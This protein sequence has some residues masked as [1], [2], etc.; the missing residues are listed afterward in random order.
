Q[1]V[2]QNGELVTL[3]HQTHGDTG[4]RRLHRYTGVHQRQGSTADRGH[5]GRTVGLGDFRDHADGVRELVFLRQ[6]GSNTTAGQAA[7]ADFAATG[8]A[9]AATLTD[10][11]RREVVVQHE[12]VLL[13]A[14]QGIEQLCIARGT[15]GGND[16]RLGFT[17]G[18]QGRAMGPVQYANFDLQRTYSA[19]VTTVDTRLAINDVLANGAVFDLT[20]SGLD[21]IGGEFAFAFTGQGCDD[22]V[23]QLV[24]TAVAVLL[25]G[26]G[27]GLA[28]G[29]A[30]LAADG[31]QQRS[32][33]GRSLPVPGRLA[34]FSSE[35]L[36]GLDHRLE[37]LM[38]EQYGA[39]HL[40]FGQ[41]VRFGFHHQHGGLG[42]GH[43]HVQA[44]G[45]ELLVVRVQQVAGVRVE[46]HAGSTDRA[47]ERNAGNGQGSGGTDHRSDVR[48]GLLAGGNNGAD[49]LHFVHEAFGEQRT[50]RTVDQAR[51]Q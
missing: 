48:I 31:V 21:L 28:D 45:L 18:E 24:Q 4:N 36:D 15:E 46:G 12:G 5:G 10:R 3:Q 17:T 42:T 8:T 35:F 50:D 16:Q 1:D 25:D 27:V 29:L 51:G 9:H 32:V 6:H 26:D 44:G 37:F 23:T 13:L 40:V 33:G 43:D 11:E 2:G 47:V 49:N 7:V 22:L 41:L 20:E 14:F 30:E 38:G 19:G 39:E 34:S